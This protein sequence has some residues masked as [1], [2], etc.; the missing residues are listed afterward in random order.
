[1][2]TKIIHFIHLC[3]SHMASMSFTNEFLRSTY[4]L[5]TAAKSKQKGPLEG[6][7]LYSIIL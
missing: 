2:R 4:F 7:A 3:A 5:P 1:V 6:N